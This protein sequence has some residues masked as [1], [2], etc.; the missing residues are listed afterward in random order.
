MSTDEFDLTITDADPTPGRR[1]NKLDATTAPTA[2]DDSAAG[3]EVGSRWVDVTADKGYECVDSTAA[4][5]VWKQTSGTGS[6]VTD[7]G[8]LTGLGDDDHPQYAMTSL[9]PQLSISG[10]YT[11]D[12]ATA[13][14]HDLT[15]TGNATLTPAHTAAVAGEAIDLRVLVRGGAGGFTLGFGGTIAWAGGSAPSAP[16]AGELLSLGFLSVD[17]AATWLGYVAGD[18][19]LSLDDLTDVTITAGAEGDYLRHDGTAWVDSPLVLADLSALGLVG[20][21]VMSE[22]ITDPPEPV[23]TEDG[24]DYIYSEPGQ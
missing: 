11:V 6:G 8:A 14:T 22:G 13:A 18:P 15:L 19:T 12:R 24:S 21:I 1:R 4:A 10:A 5:A 2:T 7:H 17:D 23:W 3:Y 16:G 9:D 20:S